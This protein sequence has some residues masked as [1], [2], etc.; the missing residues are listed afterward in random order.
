MKNFKRIHSLFEEVRC[1]RALRDINI[2]L[3]VYNDSYQCVI[4]K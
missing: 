1:C 2:K 3:I 4:S